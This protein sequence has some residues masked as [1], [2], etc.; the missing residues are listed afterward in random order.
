MNAKEF[1]GQVRYVDRAIDSKLEQ[2]ER[3]RTESTKATS[4]VS[5]M[6]RGNSLNHQRLENT[7][8]KIID[9]EHEI[10]RDIDRLIDLKKAARESINTMSN[11]DERLILELRYLCYKTWPEIAEAMGLSESHVHR[12]HGFALISFTVPE[13]PT[14]NGWGFDSSC[15]VEK[16]AVTTQMRGNNSE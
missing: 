5:D 16:I 1:L 10:N 9:L 7:I 4:L 11:P 6:P 13:D 3:L 2:A 12:L 14:G 15:F 8:I